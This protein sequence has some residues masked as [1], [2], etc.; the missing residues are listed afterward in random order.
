MKQTLTLL[1]VLL[2]D[3]LNIF[4]IKSNNKKSK[5]KKIL[6]PLILF[7]LLMYSVG[8]YAYMFAKPLHE[9]HT[10]YICLSLFIMLISV[11]IILQGF[12]KAQGILFECKDN[13]LLFSLPIKKEK[14]FLARLLKF[15]IFQYIYV[16]L[17]FLPA[18]VV[19]S[20]FEQPNISFYFISLIMFILIPIIPT[21][22]ASVI[23]YAVKGLSVN[24]KNKKRIQ[25]IISI[26]FFVIIYYFS[27]SM[28]NSV[29]SIVNKAPM[30]NKIITKLYFP[31]NAYMS[32]INK[33]DILVFIKLI[34]FNIIPLIF[35]VYLG[36]IY[37]Y[38]IIS[39]SAITKTNKKTKKY[40]NS[41]IKVRNKM[42]SL[43]R[44]EF[45]YYFSSPVYIINTLFG[46]V[47]MLIMTIYFCSNAQSFVNLINSDAQESISLATITKYA[48]VIYFEMVIFISFMTSITSSSISLE[49]KKID[50]IK[51]L[52]ISE[53]NIIF[54]KILFSLIIVIPLMLISDLIFLIFFQ[55]KLID[56]I[57]I[58]IATI[59]APTLSAMIGILI[60][61]KYPKLKWTNEVEVIKQSLSSM[62]A[63]FL[64]MGLGLISILIMINFYKMTYIV[65]ILQLLIF[66][67]GIVILYLIICNYGV[68]KF[69][70]LNY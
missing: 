10:T 47:L 24:F 22:I 53:K 25:T 65:I 50:I 17:I 39:K 49:G 42:V 11:F 3:G 35:F 7:T 13:D 19:Y 54:S 34:L 21:I 31:I 45:K 30:I 14:I 67:I 62:V 5:V 20:Y 40:K 27:F 2:K 44:K 29:N 33:F 56:S 18:L 59:I 52:P 6:F 64:G 68:K 16:L 55:V 15:L 36:S 51:S 66:A 70:S 37:Y 1:K 69:R 9:I 57:L 48:P 58:I 41:N 4:K 60:N 28:E 12:F 26:I 32:L 63:I 46:I 23:G 61:L 43:I 38:K 8:V